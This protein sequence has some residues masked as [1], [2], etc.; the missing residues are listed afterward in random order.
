MVRFDFDETFGDDYLHFYLPSLS[1]ETNDAEADQIVSLL[2][3]ESGANI[4][5]VPCGHGRI[6]NRLARRGCHVTGV[7]RTPQFLELARRDAEAMGVSVDYVQGDMRDLPWSGQF[8]AVVCW[9]TSFGYFDDD[10]NHEVLRQFRKALRPGGAV[11]IETLHHDSLARGMTRPP[12]AFTRRVGDDV[13]LDHNELDPV[14]GRLESDRTIVRD[15]QVKTT[16]FSVRLPTA[17]EFRTW[18]TD[19]GFTDITF[20]G[21]DGE[22]LTLDTW[23]LVVVAR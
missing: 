11:L 3:L 15:G 14:T 1:D 17:P 21:R 8:D 23:R 6:A 13:L 19:A 22:P 12:F 16:H 9:F 20:S 2:G 18:L 4:L 7:D 10:E 5:D